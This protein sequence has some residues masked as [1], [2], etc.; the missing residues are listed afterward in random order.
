M[1]DGQSRADAFRC[2]AALL[3]LLQMWELVRSG[4]P[5]PFFVVT[6]ANY[7]TMMTL[8]HMVLLPANSYFDIKKA[9]AVGAAS[10]PLRPPIITCRHA[11]C[12][13]RLLTV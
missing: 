5:E 8:F 10:S 11:V 9:V 6:R 4:G 1:L 7:E 2:C 12:G 3:L 13:G